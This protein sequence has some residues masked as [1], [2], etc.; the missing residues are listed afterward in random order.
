MRNL[1]LNYVKTDDC[2]LDAIAELV[3]HSKATQVN[4]PEGV[5]LKLRETARWRRGKV[6]ARASLKQQ[7][8]GHMDHIWPGLVNSHEETKGLFNFNDFWCK[9]IRFLLEHCPTPSTGP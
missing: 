9:T 4:L 7:I 3:I 5:D 8:R 6:D 2:D 1:N